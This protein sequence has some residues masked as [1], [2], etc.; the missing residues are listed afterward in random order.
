MSAEPSDIYFLTRLQDKALPLK[1]KVIE[2]R[3][4]S[5]KSTVENKY[6]LNINAPNYTLQSD[7]HHTIVTALKAFKYM[8]ENIED[9][10]FSTPEVTVDDVGDPVIRSFGDEDGIIL[11]GFENNY[12][13]ENRTELRD[14]FIN[15]LFDIKIEGAGVRRPIA[16]RGKS[17]GLAILTALID[18]F[19]GQEP[20]KYGL[21]SGDDC[22]FSGEID[23]EGNIWFVDGLKEKLEFF[24][25]SDR[26]KTLILPYT[27]DKD[28]PRVR[29]LFHYLD[30]S[31]KFLNQKHKD[32]ILCKDIYEVLY[33]Y[34]LFFGI[35]QKLLGSRSYYDL[36]HN[37]SER[38][39]KN[40]RIYGYS[41]SKEYREWTGNA[42]RSAAHDLKNRNIDN[43]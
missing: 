33:K 18:S 35:N 11:P 10:I 16:L 3:S 37:N 25:G 19:K 2:S 42:L 41:Q 21:D 6:T 40:I 39:G 28:E 43:N 32:I 12:G 30:V 34:R 20:N 8:I 1:V 14:R 4:L 5:I 27:D 22:V 24:I 29:D 9:A 17:A 13:K 15:T 23:T 26:F 36:F 38:S 7:F 31:E